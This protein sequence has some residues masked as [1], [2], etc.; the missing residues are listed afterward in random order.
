M[1]SQKLNSVLFPSLDYW[2]Q[3]SCLPFRPMWH[4]LFTGGH[5][6]IA[7]ITKRMQRPGRT[8]NLT[9]C[10]QPQ[11]YPWDLS[12][13]CP[14]LHTDAQQ[15]LTRTIYQH[16]F[17]KWSVI[18]HVLLQNTFKLGWLWL[19]LNQII[20]LQT[21][22]IYCFNFS[23]LSKNCFGSCVQHAIKI[24]P[25]NYIYLLNESHR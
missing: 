16:F 19:Y 8:R 6:P 24:T 25:F 18:M 11:L 7:E 21:E 15:L 1:L 20:S 10:S 3:Y 12:R 14:F 9:A 22:N 23:N 13:E 17:N 4:F 2:A 5:S